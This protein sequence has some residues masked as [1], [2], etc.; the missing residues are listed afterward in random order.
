MISFIIPVF[1]SA[2]ALPELYRRLVST[3]ESNAKKFE[4]LFIEDNGRDK[5][6]DVIQQ[7]AAVDKRVRG[8]QLSRNYGQQSW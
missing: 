6:W 8:F 1:R 2:E 7:L 5:S 3:F 4:I